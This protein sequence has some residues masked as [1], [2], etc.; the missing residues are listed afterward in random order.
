MTDIIGGLI[1]STSIDSKVLRICNRSHECGES[2]QDCDCKNTH[3]PEHI[4]EDD[5]D[6]DAC[7]MITRCV[8]MGT[9]VQCVPWDDYKKHYDRKEA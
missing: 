7:V 6:C 9:P 1:F 2:G 4:N 8:K 3:I 5:G